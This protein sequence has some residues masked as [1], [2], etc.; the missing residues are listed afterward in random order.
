[1]SSTRN[2]ASGRSR[3]D[4]VHISG[5]IPKKA[6]NSSNG[7]SSPSKDTVSSSAKNDRSN[8]TDD[9]LDAITKARMAMMMFEEV[10]GEPSSYRFD[11]VSSNGGDGKEMTDGKSRNVVTTQNGG[12]NQDKSTN[13]DHTAADE[14]KKI[15]EKKRQEKEEERKRQEEETRQRQKADGEAKRRAFK[16]KIATALDS[17]L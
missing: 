1:M 15:E 7:A 10:T 12:K 5:R 17:L 16:P 13:E 3:D 6:K 14:A 11:S 4:S 2:H 9:T 8:A